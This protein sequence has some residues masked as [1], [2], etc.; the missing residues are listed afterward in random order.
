MTSTQEILCMDSAVTRLDELGSIHDPIYY[1]GKEMDVQILNDQHIQSALTKCTE[2][3]ISFYGHDRHGKIVL[4]RGTVNSMI[5]DRQRMEAD[6]PDA[7]LEYAVTTKHA[8]V[9][10]AA[11]P[12]EKIK[13]NVYPRESADLDLT[14]DQAHELIEKLK[15]AIATA[16][17]H[18][19]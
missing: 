14:V 10:F 8:R 19:G 4:K 15:R 13:L 6:D 11:F 9:G 2:V 5:K 12:G 1:R 7:W 3:R 18:H 16:E 17:Y